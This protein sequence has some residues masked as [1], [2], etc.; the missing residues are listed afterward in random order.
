MQRV[1][2]LPHVQ[3]RQRPPGAADGVETAVLAALEHRQAGERPLDVFL[4]LLQRF[5]RDVCQGKTAERSGQAVPH[6]PAVDVDKLERAAAEVADYAVGQMQAGDDAERSQLR[7]ARPGQY[8]DFR[9]HG[10]LG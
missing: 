3:S 4:G 10:P 5:C 9:P 8:V 6:A 7:L 1:A 2:G